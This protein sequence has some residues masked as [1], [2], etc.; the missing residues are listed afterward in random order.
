MF[1]IFKKYKMNK[2]I[3]QNLKELKKIILE[4]QIS[5]KASAKELEIFYEQ[6][7]TWAR[8]LKEKQK[9]FDITI[10]NLS[11]ADKLELLMHIDRCVDNYGTNMIS[12]NDI[13]IQCL[14][15]DNISPNTKLNL[16]AFGKKNIAKSDETINTLRE[17]GKHIA[18]NN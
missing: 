6:V 15:A 3:K 14:D 4:T 2:Q 1:N 12:L 16:V 5:S 7:E 8:V 9:E 17:L 11:V 13:I 18:A 10:S